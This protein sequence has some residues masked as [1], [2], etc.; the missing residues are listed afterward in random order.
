[1][2]ALLITYDLNK[3]R[4]NYDDLIEKIKGLG[5]WWH[6]L[7]STWIVVSSLS[8]S[9]AFERMRPALDKSDSALV[10]NITGDSYSGWLTQEA[11]DWLKKHV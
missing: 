2:S 8:P 4:Q 10:L 1:M 6:Y 9:Q 7:D 11:W 5:T 3:P